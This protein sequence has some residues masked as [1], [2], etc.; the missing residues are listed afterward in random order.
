VD[1][2]R[3]KMKKL[4]KLLAVIMIIALMV[5]CT[6]LAATDSPAKTDISS[7]KITVSGTYTYNGKYQTPKYTVTITK[8][9][10]TVTLKEGTDYTVVSAAHKVAGEHV[11]SVK[12]IN[13]YT[14]KLSV[15]GAYTIKKKTQSV[16]VSTKYKAVAAKTFKKKAKSYKISVKGVKEKGKVTYKTNSKKITVKNGKITLKKGIKKGTYKVTVTVAATKNYKK[17]TK[18]LKIKVK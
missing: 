10:K 8:D 6:A 12:G 3:T 5:P 4:K 7:G 17:T 18:T 1:E 14:G 15:K 2:R 9:G 11:I 16:K 13:N